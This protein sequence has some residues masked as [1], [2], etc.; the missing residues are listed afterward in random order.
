MLA[1]KT[2]W[3]PFNKLDKQKYYYTSIFKLSF[4]K[5]SVILKLVII[6]DILKSTI[7]TIVG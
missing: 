4:K 3:A 2:L 1:E 7:I 5:F 6:I